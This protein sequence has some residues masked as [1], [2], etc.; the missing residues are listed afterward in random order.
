MGA[1]VGDF[2]FP[3]KLISVHIH[4]KTIIIILLFFAAGASAQPNVIKSIVQGPGASYEKSMGTYTSSY[5]NIASKFRD[6]EYEKDYRGA[7]DE[8][9]F[10]ENQFLYHAFTVIF[11]PS[12]ISK[13][14]NEKDMTLFMTFEVDG[15]LRDIIFLLWNNT[16][17][18]PQKLEM[19]EKELVDKYKIKV[20]G[21]SKPGIKY[22]MSTCRINFQMIAEGSFKY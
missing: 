21:L 18:T 8:T 19:L 17:I 10:P 13:L 11:S 16:V 9:I 22:V 14:R 7:A 1:E 6:K 2:K 4:M 15:T 5:R 3:T 20:S 12:E